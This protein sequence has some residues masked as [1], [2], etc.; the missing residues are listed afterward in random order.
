MEQKM[1]LILLRGNFIR[2]RKDM[3][4]HEQA[5]NLIKTY[6]TSG[7]FKLSSS[8]IEI[9][10]WKLANSVTKLSYVKKHKK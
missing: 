10:L 5:N 2:V 4:S 8:Q 1:A 6:K 7:I 3:L 9:R